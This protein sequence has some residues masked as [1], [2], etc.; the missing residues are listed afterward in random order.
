[1]L[2]YAGISINASTGAFTLTGNVIGFGAANGTG[3]TTISGS[4]NTFRGIDITNASTT[5]PTSI[6]G[7]T[8]SGI[9]QTTASTGTSTS[10]QFVGI[11]CGSSDG[12]F[13]VGNVTANNVGSLDGSSTIVINS[14][15]G[16]GFA[17]GIFDFSFQGNTISN[18][19]IGSITIQGTGTN[20]FRGIFWN[21][22][23]SQLE[24]VNN[25]TIANITETQ[26]GSYAVY[27]I[28]SFSSAVSATGNVVRNMIGNANGAVV[29]MGGLIISAGSST[30][31]NTFSQNTVH[32]LSN[33]V[34]G[35]SSGAVYAMDF[36]LPVQSNVIERNLAHSIGQFYLCQLPV[37]GNRDAGAGD[38]YIQE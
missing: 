35:G 10:T 36:T 23:T 32:S 34:T 16:T 8:I 27:G 31:A 6:Q 9:N 22:S 25:N 21:T 20:G 14:S 18:N 15:A 37:V 13:N 7:N 26:V 4:T 33:T 17:A 3:T 11:M 28:N 2:R 30:Q 5:V 1:M 19:N 29:T 12:R 38:G 24:T